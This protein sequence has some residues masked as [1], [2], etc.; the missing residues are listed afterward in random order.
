MDDLEIGRIPW[1]DVG[2]KL[3]PLAAL[4]SLLFLIVACGSGGGDSGSGSSGG[5]GTTP[6]PPAPVLI[7]KQGDLDERFL[8]GVFVTKETDQTIT[9]WQGSRLGEVTVRSAALKFTFTGKDGDL[10]VVP[11]GGTSTW[12]VKL[13]YS[14][15]DRFIRLERTANNT[16]T[17]R[18]IINEP[19]TGSG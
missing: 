4:A 6:P 16:H 12:N 7:A 13:F 8:S 1:Y 14:P 2:M 5:G 10:F 9:V 17:A 15:T 18:W 3:A 19:P 11:V